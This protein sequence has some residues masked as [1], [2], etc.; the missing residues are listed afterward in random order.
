MSYLGRRTGSGR[1]H[2]WTGTDTVCR[3]YSTGGL[4]PKK[5]V[6]HR[7]SD[8]RKICQNCLRNKKR[9]AAK[10]L[11]VQLGSFDAKKAAA[12]QRYKESKAEGSL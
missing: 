8:H 11:T 6:V 10:R 5:Y 12:L 1:L 3:M 7:D 2:L 4:N 9:N